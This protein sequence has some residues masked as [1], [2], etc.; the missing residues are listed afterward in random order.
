ME[1]FAAMHAESARRG[2]T[3]WVAGANMETD[4]FEDAVIAWRVAR[5]RRLVSPRFRA[6]PRGAGD[7][8]Q[9]PRR[10]P[11]YTEEQRQRAL[12]GDLGGLALPRTLALFAAGMCARYIGPPVYDSYFEV[13]ALPLVATLT[14]IAAL[15]ASAGAAA[16]LPPRV[17]EI[18]A[19][20]P[21]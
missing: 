8:P 12:R 1:L 16:P 13:F 19:V 10:R 21:R 17:E 11:G 3:H 18:D 4:C 7:L 5:E 14:D 15:R 6:L 9:T 20:H 2:I